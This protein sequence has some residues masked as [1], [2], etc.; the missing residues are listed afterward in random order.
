MTGR[1]PRL[2]FKDRDGSEFP[3][4]EERRISEFSKIFA[5]ATP[6]TKIPEYWKDGTILWMSSGEV[7]NS[8]ITNV[9]KKITKLGF[10]NSSTKM[11]KPDSVV[12]ALAGQ[13]KTRGKVAY[14]QTELCTNQSLASIETDNSVLGLY[15]FFYLGTQYEKLRSLSSGDG[16]RGGLNLNLISSVTVPIPSLPEQ[17]RIA[18]LFSAL[19][20][21]IC[22]AQRKIDALR[23]MKK[24]LLQQMF[25]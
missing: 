20:G 5:G 18:S 15:L 7:N 14:I 21:R 23:S 22:A 16:I 4:W 6:S 25:V 8:Y 24:G 12:V 10:D 3:K 2:R 11:V 9:E 19:D 13:G 1:T 17:Q